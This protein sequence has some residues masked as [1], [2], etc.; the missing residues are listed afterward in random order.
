MMRF[1]A[2]TLL[3]LAAAAPA[4]AAEPA[5]TPAAQPERSQRT[6]CR[7]TAATGSILRS[8]RIC[9]TQA[10]WDARAEQDRERRDQDRDSRS[11]MQSGQGR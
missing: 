4:L 6:V 1:V 8:Q 10:E 7:Q 2:F 5:Q 3:S 9:R 11:P